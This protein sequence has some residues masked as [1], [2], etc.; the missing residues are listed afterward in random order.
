MRKSLWIILIVLFATMGAPN[1][2][3]D[4]ITV[5][6]VITQPNE[7][8]PAMFNPGL[9]N[10]MAGDLYSFTLN[11]TGSIIAPG[12]YTT[13][14]SAD[15]ADLTNPADESSFI[16]QSLT[17]TSSGGMDTFTDLVCLISASDCTMGNELDLNFMI[18]SASLN[19]GGVVARSVPLLTPLDL[20]EDG[21]TT[22]IQGTVTSYSY[23]SAVSTVPEPGS[24]ALLGSGLFLLALARRKRQPKRPSL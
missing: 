16:S 19:L 12:T 6:G 13:F 15:F 11:F 5:G 24:L 10:I 20:L 8:P 7:N 3:A 17:I 18:P 4:G 21:G 9:D 22:D 2:H 14:T 23:T 1:A